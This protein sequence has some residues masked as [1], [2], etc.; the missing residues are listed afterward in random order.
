MM[1]ED[2]VA[3]FTQGL[4]LDEAVRRF[5]NR[6]QTLRVIQAGLLDR[7]VVLDLQHEHDKMLRLRRV[8]IDNARRVIDAGRRS[9]A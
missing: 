5:L 3:V 9:D 1:D 4:V 7:D 6:V 8:R 2:D